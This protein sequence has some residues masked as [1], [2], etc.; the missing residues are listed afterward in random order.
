MTWKS[1]VI[2][3]NTDKFNYLKTVFKSSMA[4]KKKLYVISKDKLKI[5]GKCP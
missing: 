3:E 4:K 2:K 5:G 1:D